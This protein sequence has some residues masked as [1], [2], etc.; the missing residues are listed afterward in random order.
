MNYELYIEGVPYLEGELKILILI[1]VAIVLFFIY[2][3][4]VVWDKLRSYESMKYEFITIIAHKFRTPLT[5]VKWSLE[6]IFDTEQDPFKK[7]SLM[8][9]K[10]SNETLI[11]LTNTLVEITDSRN[12]VVATYNFERINICELVGKVTKSL[13]V[14]FHEKNLFL[15]I[16]FSQPEIFVKVDKMRMEYALQ[17]I[18][19]NSIN[20]SPIGRNVEIY[21]SKVNKKAI[22]TVVDH[23]I[24]IDPADMK[25]IFS[26]LYRGSNAKAMDTEGFGVG[27][28]LVNSI[29]KGNS[30]KLKLSSEGLD[31]GTTFTITLPVVK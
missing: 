4:M 11:N 16:K 31:R 12:K 1:I 30:G 24:G 13:N 19:E 22:I 2:I 14:R 18:M 23:G 17:T 3:C 8:N 10:Q 25:N 20:Y 26:N 28:F 6:T 7:E 27:L 9:I 21:V 29:V 5:K 15:S